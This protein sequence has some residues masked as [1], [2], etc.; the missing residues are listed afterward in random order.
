[1]VTN[2]RRHTLC[3]I[4]PAH[5]FSGKFLSFAL[6]Q[7]LVLPPPFTCVF[8]PSEHFQAFSPSPG[9]QVRLERHLISV[10]P[11]SRVR[12]RHGLQEKAVG[13]PVS[14]NFG[15]QLSEAIEEI[16]LW[17]S[18]E[19]SISNAARQLEAEFDQLRLLRARATVLANHYNK[20]CLQQ[21]TCEIHAIVYYIG[22]WRAV[23]STCCVTGCQ[24]CIRNHCC[25]H[26]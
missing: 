19:Y 18:L 17:A 6:K 25:A 8:D 23:V 1:M 14:V 7:T 16:K 22:S 10:R 24:T 26:L 4:G 9:D 2:N 12:A 13:A 5:P 15:V 11:C 3:P 21:Y 20:A